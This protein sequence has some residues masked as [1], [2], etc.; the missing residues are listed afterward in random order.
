MRGA[1]CVAG[2]P[3]GSPHEQQPAAGSCASPSCQQ[4][5]GKPFRHTT[6]KRDNEFGPKISCGKTFWG[7]QLWVGKLP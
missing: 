4:P 6:N 7:F 5:A 3:Y 1:E 2:K